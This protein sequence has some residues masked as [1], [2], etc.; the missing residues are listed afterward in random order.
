MM[1]SMVIS[2][3]PA[4]LDPS[5]HLLHS[6]PIAPHNIPNMLNTIEIILQLVNLSIDLPE[7]RYLGICHVDR[8]TGTVILLL[9]HSRRLLGQI[10]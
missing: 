3:R 10:V 7:A 5:L 4:L 8:I 6:L 1:V 2:V 9:R